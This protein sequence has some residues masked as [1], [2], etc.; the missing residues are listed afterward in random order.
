[1]HKSVSSYRD[2]YKAH[3]AVE[4]ETGLITAAAASVVWVLVVA[5]ATH[6]LTFAAHHSACIALVSHHFPGSLRGRG[7]ALYII[8][9][10][11]IP[12]VL[13]GLLGGQ[14]SQH[15]GLGSV[16]WGTSAMAVLATG[17]AYRVWRMRHPAGEAAGQTAA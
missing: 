10:Y 15:W 12:G 4:P 11:G 14:L 3:V 16:F 6:A 7:Q 8:I 1:M 2:G 13:G 5:Q 17:C 9:G